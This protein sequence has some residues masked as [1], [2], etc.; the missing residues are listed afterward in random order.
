MN[1]L[2]SLDYLQI[3]QRLTLQASSLLAKHIASRGRGGGG[4]VEPL[5]K[6]LVMRGPINLRFDMNVN[7]TSNFHLILIT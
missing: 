4:F 7:W 6:I 2:L 5:P 1:L 3:Q